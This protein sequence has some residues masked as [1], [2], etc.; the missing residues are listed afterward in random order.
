MEAKNKHYRI[1]I[2]VYSTEDDYE[3]FRI[4]DADNMHT[5]QHFNQTIDLCEIGF[6]QYGEHIDDWIEDQEKEGYTF[7]IVDDYR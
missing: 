2:D 7:D 4:L 3:I 5:S 6:F 1:I